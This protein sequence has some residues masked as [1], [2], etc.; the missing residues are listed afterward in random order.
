MRAGC[1][2]A[3]YAPLPIIT[4]SA[5]E[6]FECLRRVLRRDDVAID[7]HRDMYGL[8]DG[9]HG[10]PV[11]T[12]LEELAAGAAMHRHELDAGCL[13][14]SRQL[15]RI[16]GPVVPA[17]AHLERDGNRHGTD[18]RGDQPDRVI[19]ITHERTARE[20]TRHL[21]RRAPHVDID[22]LGA[23]PFGQARALGH[24]SSVTA[25]KL[26]DEGGQVAAHGAAKTS[27]RSRTSSR[28]ATISDTTRPA[29]SR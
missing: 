22:D 19:E 7:D 2:G 1:Q 25:N 18:N 3:P 6:A 9:A 29:P 8:F 10:G 26:Y 15:R 13:R 17:Q 28:L 23:E 14:P 20:L 16:T 5:P 21:A 4:A 12:A 24:P 11:R 27:A